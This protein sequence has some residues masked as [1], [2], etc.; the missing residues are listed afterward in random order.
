MQDKHHMVTK[1]I[2]IVEGFE[3][4]VP[5]V[6]ILASY[7]IALTKGEKCAKNGFINQ[8]GTLSKGVG[9]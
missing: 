3:R 1:V 5:F 2:P 9:Y 6:W 7:E 8:L 4:P